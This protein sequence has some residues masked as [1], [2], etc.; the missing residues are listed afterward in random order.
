MN[1]LVIN[2]K[3]VKNSINATEN[4]TITH[5]NYL[6]VCVIIYT[7]EKPAMTLLSAILYNLA[8]IKKLLTW[9]KRPKF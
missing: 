6:I 9:I 2:S 7:I 3:V 8:L 4:A 1:M 5:K